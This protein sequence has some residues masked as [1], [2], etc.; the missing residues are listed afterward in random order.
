MSNAPVLQQ[1]DGAVARITVNRPDKLNALNAEVIAGLVAAFAAAGQDRGVRVVV[2][3]G[4]GEKSFVAGADIGELRDL[5]ADAARA[6]TRRGHAL[7][8]RIENLGK[9]VIAALNGYALGGGCELAL[10]CTLRV[11]SRSAMLGLPEVKLGLIPGYGGTQRLARLVGPGRALQMM[12]T[13]DP[14]GAEQAQAIG[15]VN[16][17]VEPEELEDTVNRLASRLANGAPLA[18]RAIVGAVHGGQGLPLA[19]ALEVEVEAFAGLAGSDD[20]REGIA[21]FMEKRAAEFKGE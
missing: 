9:P 13:G 7:M 20:M 19:E 11:A 17:V 14:I 8:S 3:T 4:A 18:M 5:D 15:L 10:A 2:L 16:D 1:R 12:L 21:A 6:L